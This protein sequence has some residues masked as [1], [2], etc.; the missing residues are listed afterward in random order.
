M[1]ETQIVVEGALQSDG[2]LVLD[3]KPN[4]PPG[5]VRV[6]MQAMPEPIRP[7]DDSLVRLQKIWAAQDA[8]GYVPR[9]REEVDAEINQLRD[10]A[11][12][13]MQAVERL[14]EECERA[15]EQQEQQEPSR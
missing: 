9:T 12:E 10:E 1:S 7:E 5:R 13:E 6:T 4:L 3:E 15:R 8:R 11:E 2:T 14:Y